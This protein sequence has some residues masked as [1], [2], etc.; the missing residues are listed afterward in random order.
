M[1]RYLVII[2]K[3]ENQ[4]GF[5]DETD[6]ILNEDIQITDEDY[7]RVH[8]LQTQGK[9]FILKEIST[10]DTLF[11]YIEEYIP[12]SIEVIQ[13]LGIDEFMLET[14]FRLS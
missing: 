11:D 7:N 3:E 9:Q 8:E 5:K 13:K 14:D 12:Q 1:K 10:S 2:N 6:K 4:F